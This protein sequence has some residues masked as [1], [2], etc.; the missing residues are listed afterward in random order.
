MDEIKITV[1]SV[2]AGWQTHIGD[3]PIGP[4]L[5]EAT[6]VWNWQATFP[7]RAFYYATRKR[8][9]L[10]ITDGAPPDSPLAVRI[11]V[12]GKKNARAL[13]ARCYAKPHNF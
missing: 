11:D 2:L 6:A 13:A 1:R 8:K 10:E 4:V 3:K 9:F 12:D 5:L 7:L